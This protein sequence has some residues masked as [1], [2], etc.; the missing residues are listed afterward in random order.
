MTLPDIDTFSVYGGPLNDYAAIEDPTVDIAAASANKAICNVAMA[1]HTLTRAICAFVTNNTSAPTDPAT[2]I[3]DA[4]WGSAI[5]VKPTVART[6]GGV[7]TITWPSTVSDEGTV[8][9]Q[10]AATHTVNLR[11]AWAN[12]ETASANA[13]RCR[14]TSPN[15]VTVEVLNSSLSAVDT[16][17]VQVCVFAI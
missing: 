4:V 11:H 16:T 13:V 17:G 12:I 9:G 10:A 15:V 3:H 5:G 6:G 1:T 14:V 7:F 2:N 8:L